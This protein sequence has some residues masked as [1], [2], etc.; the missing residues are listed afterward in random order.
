MVDVVDEA[1]LQKVREYKK[2]KKAAAKLAASVRPEVTKMARREL[3]AGARLLVMSRVAVGRR[4]G[5]I[6][7]SGGSTTRCPFT[8]LADARASTDVRDSV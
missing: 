6:D 5:A 4:H 1:S 3:L 7:A 8:T 2:E